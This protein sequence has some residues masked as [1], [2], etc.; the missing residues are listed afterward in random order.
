MDRNPSQLRKSRFTLIDRFTDE[1]VGELTIGTTTTP[2]DNTIPQITEGN[3]VFNFNYTPK[4]IGSLIRLF[5]QLM[6]SNSGASA[7]LASSLFIDSGVNAI[8]TT[9]TRQDIV[10]RLTGSI[11]RHEFV[12]VSLSPINFQI[13]SGS[14]AA[15]TII[16]NNNGN[17]ANYGD[18]I[19]SWIELEELAPPGLLK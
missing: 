1:I 11:L 10:D 5:S 2:F 7:I 3:E 16:L 4:K 15:G 13:R 17:V 14:S 9:T 8:R 18:T 19:N 12:T 6:P